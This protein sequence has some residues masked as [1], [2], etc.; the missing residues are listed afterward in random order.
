M[1]GSLVLVLTEHRRSR[2][3]MAAGAVGSQLDVPIRPSIKP[4]DVIADSA[5]VH[6][7]ASAGAAADAQHDSSS[8]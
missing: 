5:G 8:A 1:L 7:T 3:Q 2:A 4:L 6:T